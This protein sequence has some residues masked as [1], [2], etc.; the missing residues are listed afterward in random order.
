MNFTEPQLSN[1]DC[2]LNGQPFDIARLPFLS[3]TELGNIVGKQHPSGFI[4][5]FEGVSWQFTYLP[6]ESLKTATEYGE[7]PDDGWEQLYQKFIREDLENAKYS[8]EYLGRD[9]WIKN[10]WTQNTQTYPL[11]VIQEEQEYRILD[12]HHRLAGA[13][14]YKIP[15]VAVILGK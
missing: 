11:F 6:T 8:P 5:S 12:G 1:P 14:F 9:N 10:V 15:Q 7:E 4:E 2:R 3:S 13:F